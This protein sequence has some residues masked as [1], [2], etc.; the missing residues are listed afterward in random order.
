M[1]AFIAVFVLGAIACPALITFINWR[2][3]RGGDM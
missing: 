3:R 1:T 2:N